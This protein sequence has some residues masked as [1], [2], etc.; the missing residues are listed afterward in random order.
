M[1]C[2]K[3]ARDE[4]HRL[5]KELQHQTIESNKKFLNEQ[6]ERIEATDKAQQVKT[7][8][9]Y[10]IFFPWNLAFLYFSAS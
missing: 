1:E 7:S 4:V 2:E 5:E 8:T 6:K 3:T 10:L 9:L